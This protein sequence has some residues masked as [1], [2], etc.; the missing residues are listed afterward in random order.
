MYAVF[1]LVTNEYPLR[2][3]VYG[4]VGT[5]ELLTVVSFENQLSIIMYS[6]LV[7]FIT[8]LNWLYNKNNLMILFIKIILI[9]LYF[10]QKIIIINHLIGVHL[11]KKMNNW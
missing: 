8:L 9:L 3:I 6:I 1:Y 2:P 5:Q 4:K 10:N 7:V 11:N